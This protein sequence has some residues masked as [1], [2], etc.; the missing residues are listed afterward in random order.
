MLK[1]NKSKVRTPDLN[2]EPILLVG[3]KPKG[4]LKHSKIEVPYYAKKVS[5]TQEKSKQEERLSE[6]VG[7]DVSSDAML[8]MRDKSSSSPMPIVSFT[9]KVFNVQ[10]KNVQKL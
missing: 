4:V 5:P 7:N 1:N 9:S 6:P 2:S 8:N 3:D 10:H